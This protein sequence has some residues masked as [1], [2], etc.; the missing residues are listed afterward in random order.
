MKNI[1]Y[2]TV[3]ALCKDITFIKNDEKLRM[4]KMGNSMGGGGGGFGEV[5]KKTIKT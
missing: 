5:Y 3:G 4:W 2:S 1:G